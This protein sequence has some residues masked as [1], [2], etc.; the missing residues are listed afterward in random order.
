MPWRKPN[1]SSKNRLFP[2]N[3]IL[4]FLKSHSIYTQISNKTDH[5]TFCPAKSPAERSGYYVKMYF[6]RFLIRNL[7]YI[8]ALFLFTCQS[9]IKIP[10]ESLDPRNYSEL[11]LFDASSFTCKPAFIGIKDPPRPES[12]F[13]KSNDCLFTKTRHY[14]QYLLNCEKD[15]NLYYIYTTKIGTCFELLASF[16]RDFTKEGK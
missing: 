4:I 1:F 3:G 13:L 12:F 9:Q 15:L 6:Y 11:Y 8:L 2:W 5:E 14:D 16:K 7:G 10:P